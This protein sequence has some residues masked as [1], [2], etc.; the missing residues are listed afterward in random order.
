MEN[1]ISKCVSDVRTISIDELDNI[2]VDSLLSAESI[3]LYNQ[4]DR[5]SYINSK[6]MDNISFANKCFKFVKELRN[7][8]YKGHVILDCD[9]VYDLG[10]TL[11]NYDSMNTCFTTS[12]YSMNAVNNLINCYTYNIRDKFCQNMSKRDL[13]VGILFFQIK[14]LLVYIEEK[15]DMNKSI[16]DSIYDYIYLDLVYDIGKI[17][18]A[19]FIKYSDKDNEILYYFDNNSKEVFKYYPTEMLDKILIYLDR[20]NGFFNYDGEDDKLLEDIGRAYDEIVENNELGDVDF[21]TIYDDLLN[22]N[23]LED[24]YKLFYDGDLEIYYKL[25]LNIL[26][27][28]SYEDYYKFINDKFTGD[29][30]V[31]I[32][33]VAELILSKKKE[34]TKNKIKMSVC[35]A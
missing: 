25:L 20:N 17:F 1:N 2:D 22:C 11:F 8:G 10:N 31:D 32:N 35:N 19:N 27:D 6:S 24:L 26:M 34:L 13:F 4:E 16:S 14:E 7:K 18:G 21:C 3:C 33:T 15:R 28:L 12:L 29:I 9:S 23:C 30:N 5:N